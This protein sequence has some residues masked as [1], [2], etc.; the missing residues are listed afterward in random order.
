LAIALALHH[1]GHIGV[2]SAADQRLC[3][4]APFA[5]CTAINPEEPGPILV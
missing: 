2:L 4:V 5:G 3:R 1:H